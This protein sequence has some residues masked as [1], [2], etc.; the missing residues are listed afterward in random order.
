MVQSSVLAS[1]LCGV[2]ISSFIW[3]NFPRPSTTAA[4]PEDGVTAFTVL[5]GEVPDW[6][7]MS[8]YNKMW[9]FGDERV[10]V[11]TDSFRDDFV[12]RNLV[13]RRV[14]FG[15]T[16]RDYNARRNT[17]LSFSHPDPRG[18]ALRTT[19]SMRLILC[20]ENCQY[21]DT[22]VFFFK[23]I[24]FDYLAYEPVERRRPNNNNFRLSG[25]NNKFNAILRD[26]LATADLKHDP[27]GYAYNVFDRLW[28]DVYPD[29]GTA[30][31]LEIP[32][33]H[34]RQPE[35]KKHLLADDIKF[36]S[37]YGYFWHC[38]D[39]RD[40]AVIWNAHKQLFPDIYRVDVFDELSQALSL[41]R[42]YPTDI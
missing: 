24:D 32:M 12:F 2:V 4:A 34:L 36:F 3:M 28:D 29:F 10:Y 7:A 5:T 11:Y 14:D 20:Q 42:R 6:L 30:T 22:D 41:H 35:N 39:K 31:L 19:D 15:R 40:F 21:F 27:W 26:Y 8:L 1:F 37:R 18:S 25:E 33:I 16:L 38:Y 17:S 23:K 13:F 9:I